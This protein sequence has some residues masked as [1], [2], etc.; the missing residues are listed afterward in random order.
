MK[1]LTSVL[2]S[3][4][5]SASFSLANE[6]S[7]EKINYKER[8]FEFSIDYWVAVPDGNFKVDGNKYGLKELGYGK[9]KDFGA[10][11]MYKG[12]FHGDLN[13]SF[14]YTPIKFDA[15]TRASKSFTFKDFS[16]NAGEKYES[17][18]DF[19]NYDLGFL[20]DIG[21]LKE[22]TENRLDVRAGLSIRYLDGS[23]EFKSETGSEYKKNYSSI[24]PM[25]DLEAEVEVLPINQELTAEIILELQSY[26]W[27][28]EYIHDFIDSVRVNYKHFFAEAGYRV[29]KY[30][31]KD[32]GIK[33]KTTAEGGF[34]SLGTMF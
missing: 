15:S 13:I 32:S 26:T 17:T 18:Y 3:C 6:E 28:D 11:F 10:K 31:L 4:L 33:S 24:K 22:K 5:L 30:R 21:H 27:N 12:L 23:V 1:K 20:F 14:Y 19:N 9:A 29:M 8:G 25:V 2:L 7:V 16:V 34:L